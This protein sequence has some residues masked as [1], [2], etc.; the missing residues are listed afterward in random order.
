LRWTKLK[1][2]KKNKKTLYVKQ[3]AHRL[4]SVRIQELSRHSLAVGIRE[5]FS[6]PLVLPVTLGCTAFA[7]ARNTFQS[8][9]AGAIL[10]AHVMRH[11]AHPITATHCSGI[12]DTSDQGHWNEHHCAKD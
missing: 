3:A 9:V 8:A 5:H 2:L 11:W 12:D 10:L 4:L 7:N 6:C 1:R